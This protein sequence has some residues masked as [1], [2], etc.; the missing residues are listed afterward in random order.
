MTPGTA[1]LSDH[2]PPNLSAE[3]DPEV[4]LSILE[5]DES[6]ELRRQAVI[7]LEA[8]PVDSLPADRLAASLRRFIE[9]HRDSNDPD[10][11]TAV[12]SAI[13]K[14]VGLLDIAQLAE[15]GF[16]L[17]AAHRAPVPPEIEL[18]ATKMLVR[19]FTAVG[20]P[21]PSSLEEL[22]GR[23]HELID[24]YLNPRMLPRPYYGAIALNATLAVTLLGGRRCDELLEGIRQLRVS[25]FK[26][27][28]ARRA[29]KIRDEVPADRVAQR[30]RLAALERVAE[31]EA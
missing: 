5:S 14:Y 31:S 27:M 15:V 6:P 13:R 24:T 16:I 18:E 23:L 7:E 29:R 3:C 12:A 11:L 21:Q 19:K 2:P 22:D 1:I 10:D 8:A 17:D 26:Q 20:A 30:E 4:L 28:V 25:W 9:E